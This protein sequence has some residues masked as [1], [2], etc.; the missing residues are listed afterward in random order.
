MK[1]LGMFLCGA[2]LG[3]FVPVSA[4]TWDVP[5]E[6]RLLRESVDRLAGKLAAD[7]V[8]GQPAPKTGPVLHAIGPDGAV[9]PLSVTPDGRLRVEITV[10][11]K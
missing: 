3:S 2:V 8:A 11:G 6:F 4:Q 7:G 1:Y 10:P 9:V 5:A